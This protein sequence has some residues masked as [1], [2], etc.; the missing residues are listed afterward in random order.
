MKPRIFAPVAL[1]AVLPSTSTLAR[2]P[3]ALALAANCF[4]CHGTDGNSVGNMLLKFGADPV[5]IKAAAYKRADVVGY[6]EVH[7][8]QGPQ[9]ELP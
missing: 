1:L 2:D 4:T 9:L 6:L 7:I 8:Q 3:S 5:A